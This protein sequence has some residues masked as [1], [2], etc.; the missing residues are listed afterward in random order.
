MV[1][2]RVSFPVLLRSSL[3]VLLLEYLLLPAWPG[4]SSSPLAPST[5]SAPPA[6]STL[7]AVPT[8]DATSGKSSALRATSIVTIP[9]LRSLYSQA[10]PKS[11]NS[12][13]SNTTTPSATTRQNPAPGCRPGFDPTYSY[14]CDTA[15][16]WGIVVESLATLGFLITAGLVV[17]VAGWTTCGCLCGAT[18]TCRDA[19]P[20]LLFLLGTGGIFGLSFAFIIRLTPQTCPT[21]VFLFGVL[22]SLSFS[23]LLSRCL[24]LQ[25]LR[26]SR[27]WGEVGLTLA[28]SAIQVIIATE[29]LI[30]VLV[31][32]HRP[33][34]YTQGEFVMLLIYVLCLL[35]VTLIISIRCLYRSCHTYSYSYTGGSHRHAK[36]QYILL[37][38]T[39]VLSA[40]IW[41]IWITLLTWGE[42]EMG[43]QPVWDD[44]VLSVALVSNGWV[45][46]LGHGVAQVVFLCRS[47][48]RGKDI[49]EAADRQISPRSSIPG[50]GYPKL[51]GNTWALQNKTEKERGRQRDQVLESPYESAFT[52]TDIDPN[53]DYSI[54]RPQ[55]THGYEPYDEYSIYSIAE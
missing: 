5:S 18:A 24:V 27:G 50:L 15:V 41:V 23:A 40:S 36:V 30:T 13:L 38:V 3:S 6:R 51:Q 43:R 26:V 1:W 55:T 31:Q 33:C 34:F 2:T 4:V 7:D 17:G 14:L 52:V 22:F 25:E 42:Q 28:L 45:F 47:E 46:L 16:V 10:E 53:R 20:L 12:L 8:S 11:M 21:R 35:A 44:P 9:A 49:P 37:W 54:P 19:A 39:L 32:D 29:W 48:T